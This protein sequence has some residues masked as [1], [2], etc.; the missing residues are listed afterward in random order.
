MTFETLITF[1]TIEN[2]NL[3]I[4]SYPW[5]KSDRDSI[6]NSCDVFTFSGRA[7][8]L[9]SAKNIDP[10]FPSFIVSFTP[11]SWLFLAIGGLPLPLALLD[12]GIVEPP[13][14]SLF[15]SEAP[16]CSSLFPELALWTVMLESCCCWGKVCWRPNPV[17]PLSILKTDMSSLKYS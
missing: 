12:R 11:T 13:S 10:P 9:G 5:I 16:P 15:R 8:A 7:R 17:S 1:L 14:S 2:N 4:H 6:R 3:N